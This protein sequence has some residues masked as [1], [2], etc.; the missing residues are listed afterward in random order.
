MNRKKKKD[1]KI[2]ENEMRKKQQK[3]QTTKE[4]QQTQKKKEQ[5]ALKEY[6]EWMRKKVRL[7]DCRQDEFW[8]IKILLHLSFF[9]K[10]TH[11]V[12]SC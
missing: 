5:D 3:Q 9:H 2:E 1:I 11:I 12:E 6:N 7:K 8:G 4:L 10:N